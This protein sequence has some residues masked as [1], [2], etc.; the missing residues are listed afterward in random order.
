MI[1]GMRLLLKMAKAWVCTDDGLSIALEMTRKFANP[2]IS[3]DESD[4][5]CFDAVVLYFRNCE[6]LAEKS[7]VCDGRGSEGSEEEVRS[8]PT[9]STESS[10]SHQKLHTEYKRQVFIL[11][12][13]IHSYFVNLNLNEKSYKHTSIAVSNENRNSEK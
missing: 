5:L 9:E 12:S 8:L 10:D 4:V 3:M 1:P 11:L 7:L 6:S 2:F 13:F